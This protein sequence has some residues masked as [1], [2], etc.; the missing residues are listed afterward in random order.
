MQQPMQ[1]LMQQPMQQLM[2]QPMQQLMQQ[3]MQ[4]LMQ[5][6]MQLLGRFGQF[7][8]K[9]I[10]NGELLLNIVLLII[11]YISVINKKKC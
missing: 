9:Y 5:Q 11:I 10:I 3:P 2:Q 7:G 1:Q 4:Q 8:G 6:P